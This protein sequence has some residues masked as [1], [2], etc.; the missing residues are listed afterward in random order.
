MKKMHYYS[1]LLISGV[2]PC[3]VYANNKIPEKIPDMAFLEYLA[4]MVEVNGE[5][6]GPL[7][8]KSKKIKTAQLNDKER[9]KKA[10]NETIKTANDKVKDQK[11][12]EKN[13]D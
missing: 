10:Q 6:V 3:A 8:I 7:D 5:L 2:T 11:P 1:V 13:N 9:L 4:D 12:K